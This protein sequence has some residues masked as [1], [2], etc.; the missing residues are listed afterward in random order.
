[1]A[2]FVLLQACLKRRCE[3]PIEAMDNVDSDDEYDEKIYEEHFKSKSLLAAAKA[4]AG[5]DSD[6][7]STEED[8]EDEQ[9]ENK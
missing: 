6:G 3:A 4:E 8:E 2:S 1:M 7:N 5:R 9:K